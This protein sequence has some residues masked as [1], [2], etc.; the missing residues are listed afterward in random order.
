MNQYPI[1]P[2][3]TSGTRSN[4]TGMKAFI[5]LTL[6]VLFFSGTLFSQTAYVKKYLPVAEHLEEDYGIPVAVIL[7]VAI[8]ES[9]SGTSRNSKLLNNHFGIVGKNQLLKTKG[10]KSAY[11][12]YDNVEESYEDFC[13]VLKKKKFYKG[14]KGNQDYILWIDAISKAGYSEV[15]TIWKERVLGTIKKNK[16]YNL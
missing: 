4:Q 9:G 13:K 3:T 11:K 12:Q 2:S 14:L 1:Q 15:P 8:L 7:G 6:A 5:L 16:L 10:I